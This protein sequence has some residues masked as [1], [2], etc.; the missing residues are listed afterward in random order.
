[1]PCEESRG[2]RPGTAP[3]MTAAVALPSRICA[4]MEEP[5]VVEVAD[6]GEVERDPRGG[7]GVDGQLVTNRA[8][9]LDDG[10]DTALDEDLQAIGE[11]EER[12]AGRDRPDRTVPSPFHRQAGRVH[13]LDLPHP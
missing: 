5:L 7:S 1:M 10:T 9:R 4:V 11:R 12:I 8:T 2:T 13:P 3:W 6:A